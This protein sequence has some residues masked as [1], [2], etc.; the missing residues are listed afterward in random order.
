MML[1]W[2][3]VYF[4]MVLT[5]NPLLIIFLLLIFYGALDW[6]YFGFF[7]QINR[8]FRRSLEIRE[9]NRALGINPHDAPSQVA[10]GRAY[11]L[12]GE[13]QKGIPP[14]QAAFQKMKD[15]PDVHYYLGLAYLLTGRETEGEELL[16]NTIRMDPRFQYG[17]PYLKLGEHFLKIRNY[18]A[19]LGML[20]TFCSIHTSSS[21]GYYH[22]GL[23]Q[24]ALGDKAGA[25]KSFNR[26]IEAYRISP[27]YKKQIDR[28]WR[29][30]AGRSLATL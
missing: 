10:L 16:L 2:M 25:A 6:R 29:W 13:P 9:L 17:E 24:V 23:A 14:L 20:E 30:K 3:V 26:S 15:L 7:P 22:L 18:K 28:K 19:G 27:S 11:F 4:L 8:W 12:N 1:K 21:E 5:G